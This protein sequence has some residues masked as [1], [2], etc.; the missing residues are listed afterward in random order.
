M[1]GETAEVLIGTPNGIVRT[2]D[3]RRLPDG[4]GRWSATMAKSM[5]T[6]FEE[7]ID[8]STTR[9]EAITV[10]VPGIETGL[11]PRDPAVPFTVRRL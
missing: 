7:Y 9:P 4:P 5:M 10:R 1:S 2:S 11:I 6:T 8:P 3:I